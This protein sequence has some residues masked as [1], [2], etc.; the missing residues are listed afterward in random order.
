MRTEWISEAIV[1]GISLSPHGSFSH[2][3]LLVLPAAA[4]RAGVVA[5]CTEM[6]SLTR[7]RARRRLSLNG[8]L[9]P[10]GGELFEKRPAVGKEAL[11]SRAQIVQPGLTF[12]CLENAILRAPSVTKIE[13]LACQTIAG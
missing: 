3:T 9:S 10:K 12:G 8:L 5:T 4:A 2:T 1:S 11:V 13:D 6:S 7:G